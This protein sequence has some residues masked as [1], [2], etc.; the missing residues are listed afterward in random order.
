MKKPNWRR[1]KIF[2]QLLILGWLALLGIGLLPGPVWG[3]SDYACGRLCGFLWTLWTPFAWVIA[4]RKTSV[5][6]PFKQLRRKLWSWY[7]GIG[8]GIMILASFPLVLTGNITASIIVSWLYWFG[9][10]WISW[11][12][13]HR[14]AAVVLCCPSSHRESS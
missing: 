2:L 7:I 3:A 4:V 8:F 6:T 10:T 5:D 9:W 12:I 13:A 1:L 14:R 11:L